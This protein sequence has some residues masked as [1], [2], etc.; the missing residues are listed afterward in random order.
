MTAA[1]RG[2]STPCG[3]LLGAVGLADWALGPSRD[4]IGI[5]IIAAFRADRGGLPSLMHQ[6]HCSVNSAAVQCS[7]V[8][9]NQMSG[10][11]D[12]MD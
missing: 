5:D 7:G 3:R 2:V 9:G 11:V 4:L 12:Q 8:L 6:R 1:W 10:L